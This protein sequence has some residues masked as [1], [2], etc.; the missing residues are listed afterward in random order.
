MIGEKAVRLL[1]G[2]DVKEG[3][4]G[5]LGGREEEEGGG[6]KDGRILGGFCLGW[7][8]IG[9]GNGLGGFWG[10]GCWGFFLR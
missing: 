2:R 9:G 8:R 1:K 10:W 5:V 4:E 6:T 3:E 7:G